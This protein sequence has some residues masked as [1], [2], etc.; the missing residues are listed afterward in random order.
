MDITIANKYL[1]DELPSP[2]TNYIFFIFKS[3]CCNSAS[4]SGGVRHIQGHEDRR[5]QVVTNRMTPTPHTDSRYDEGNANSNTVQGMLINY[6][7]APAK[8]L[9]QSPRQ[10]KATK[11]SQVKTHGIETSN[12]LSHAKTGRIETNRRGRDG[13]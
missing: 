6:V 9:S 4:N 8:R 11:I 13:E 1:T 7:Q 5:F 12:Q 3:T 2:E 10:E